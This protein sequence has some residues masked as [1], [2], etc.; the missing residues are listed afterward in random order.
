VKIATLAN[1]S[2]IHTRR[3]VEH[4]RARGHDVRLWS[5]EPGPAALLAQRLPR[6]PLPGFARYP[7]AAPALR[8]AFASFQPD[9]VDAHYVP[10]YGVLGALAGRRPLVI[11]AW[12]SDLLVAGRR[13]PLQRARARFAM[14]RAD[15]VLVDAANLG[16]AALA[17]GAPRERLHVVPWGVDRGRF[18]PAAAREPGLLVSARMHEP[19]YDLETIIA[20]TAPVLERR[21]E[22]RLVIAGEGS[23]RRGL[24]ALAARRLPAGRYTFVGRLEPVELAALLARAELYLSA[25]LSDSTSVSLLEAMAC[26]A[27]PVVSDIDGNREWVGEGDGARLFPAGDPEALARAALGALDDASWMAAARERN[28]RVIE[29]R[30]DWNV[31]LASIEALFE[32]LAAGTHGPDAMRRAAA[33]PRGGAVPRGA[34]E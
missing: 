7:L 8:R 29:T 25:S 16:A 30:G 15:A 24:E 33:G 10:N 4:F 20:G 17:L 1:A 27:V 32:R 3:W 23:L 34:R 5:L 21:P 19:I 13:D 26:G 2:V 22:A 9:V 18:H 28:R 12:G 14:R 31:N 6:F 11:S